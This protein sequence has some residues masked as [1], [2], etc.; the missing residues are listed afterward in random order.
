MASRLRSRASLELIKILA[1]GEWYDTHYLALAA[2]KYIPPERAS[3]KTPGGTVEGGRSKMIYISLKSFLDG[4]RVETRHKGR[5]AE[6][7]LSN[8]QWAAKMLKWAGE[9]IPLPLLAMVEMRTITLSPAHY[10]VLSQVKQAYEKATG[11]SVTWDAFLVELVGSSL[12]GKSIRKEMGNDAR[13]DNTGK[14]NHSMKD[15]RAKLLPK[16]YQ[17]EKGGKRNP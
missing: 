16:R 13:E 5:L 9:P 11:K 6:W 10:D 17:S 14:E 12:A 4:G 3:R 7:R 2:G 1:D 8:F 15:P